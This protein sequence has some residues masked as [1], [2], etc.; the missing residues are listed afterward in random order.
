MDPNIETKKKEVLKPWYQR[1]WLL[2]L[3]ISLI[4]LTGSL[5]P[6]PDLTPTPKRSESQ[7]RIRR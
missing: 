3:G 5:A 6:A 4:L 1:Y 2:I 7:N